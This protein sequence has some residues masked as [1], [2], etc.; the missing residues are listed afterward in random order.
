MSSNRI[1]QTKQNE[2][3]IRMLRIVVNGLFLNRNSNRP[4]TH[5]SVLNHKCKMFNE[6]VVG[7]DARVRLGVKINFNQ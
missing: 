3:G 1:F 6:F 5:F 7:V 4:I 2:N